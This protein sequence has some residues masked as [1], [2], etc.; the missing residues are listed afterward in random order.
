MVMFTVCVR[1]CECPNSTY[2]G[3]KDEVSIT[4]LDIMM[5][6]I[7]R[8]YG[9]WT[10][11]SPNFHGIVICSPLFLFSLFPHPFFL[12]IHLF[13]FCPFFSFYFLFLPVNF[14]FFYSYFFFPSIQFMV[15]K[16]K[17]G[18]FLAQSPPSQRILLT[19]IRQ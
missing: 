18:M 10:Y 11:C 8:T 3:R 16:S 2:R 19:A 4:I 9:L 1:V 17:R 6:A 7:M 12:F 14:F 15:K 5:Y 13:H